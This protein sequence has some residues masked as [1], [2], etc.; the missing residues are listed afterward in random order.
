MG[1]PMRFRRR[2]SGSARSTLLICVALVAIAMGILYGLRFAPGAE[3]IEQERRDATANKTRVVDPNSPVYATATQLA[4]HMKLIQCDGEPS[5][6]V[7]SQKGYRILF[8]ST[9]KTSTGQGPERTPVITRNHWDLVLV[10]KSEGEAP[11]IGKV[12]WENVEQDMVVIASYMG[13]DNSY[14]WYGKMPLTAM[15]GIR[16][17]YDLKEGEDRVA[18]FQRY[19]QATTKNTESQKALSY[20]ARQLGEAAIPMLLKEI[21]QDKYGRQ[22]FAIRSLGLIPGKKSTDLLLAFYQNEETC[23]SAQEAI[24]HHSIR[25]EAKDVYLDTLRDI[26]YQNYYI[27]KC[28]EAAVRFSWTA[29]IPSLQRIMQRPESLRQYVNTATAVRRLQGI[30]IPAELL[31]AQ[32]SLFAAHAID[33]SLDSFEAEVNLLRA[34]E[35]HE[36]VLLI[37]LPLASARWK[38]GS[39]VTANMIGVDLLHGLPPELVDPV[40]ELLAARVHPQTARDRFRKLIESVDKLRENG[41]LVIKTDLTF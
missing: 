26:S 34:H 31:K 29:A 28:V 21:E 36:S 1:A 32:E 4:K 6:R 23:R 11:K 27:P 15:D 5:V 16:Q 12:P 7:G 39:L 20:I 2:N 22:A 30:P 25:E 37:A 10:P 8:Q 24:M 14:R 33:A 35:D 9:K 38:G 18:L 17:N 41:A 13:E 40:L 3:F 19:L